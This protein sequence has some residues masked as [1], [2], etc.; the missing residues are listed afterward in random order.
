[1]HQWPMPQDVPPP[2]ELELDVDWYTRMANA[3]G[4]GARMKSILLE[5]AEVSKSHR[6]S[7][8]ICSCCNFVVFAQERIRSPLS[9]KVAVERN[10]EDGTL[11]IMHWMKVRG[12]PKYGAAY[13]KVSI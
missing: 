5:I 13:Q 1:M 8:L 12:I 10:R 6:L 3:Q 2:E 7:V 4:V 11:A 9:I